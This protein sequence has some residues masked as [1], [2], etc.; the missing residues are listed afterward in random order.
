MIE[1][2]EEM[3]E[4]A[5]VTVCITVAQAGRLAFLE[6]RNRAEKAAYVLDLESEGMGR[7]EARLEVARV[8]ADWW[9]PVERLVAASLR[10]RL[11]EEDLAGP[12]EP[13]TEEEELQMRLSGR[14]PGP[15]IGNL[16]Q[17]NYSLP[18][19]LAVQLRTASWRVSEEPFR[20]L[21]RLGI[22][23]AV[24][25]PEDLWGERERLVELLVSPARI[26]REALDRYP[27]GASGEP[28]EPI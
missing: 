21:E 8:Q 19:D 11:G 6:K 1:R 3:V 13:L 28:V 16:R 20:E 22:R 25:T 7:R 9:P 14:W 15:A 27:R 10:R 18:L 5:K 12:W 4:K 23:L 17:R 24:E 2:L 26:V